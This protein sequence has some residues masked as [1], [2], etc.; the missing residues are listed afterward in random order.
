MPP[1]QIVRI[2]WDQQVNFDM[3]HS[4]TGREPSDMPENSHCHIGAALVCANIAVVRMVC[5]KLRLR[6]WSDRRVRAMSVSNFIP[7]IQ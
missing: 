3:N 6:E 2:D 7:A 5:P 1:A 4:E